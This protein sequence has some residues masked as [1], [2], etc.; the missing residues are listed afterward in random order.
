MTQEREGSTTTLTRHR[1][2]VTSSRTWTDVETITGVLDHLLRIH[3]A[4]LVV[5]DGACP[6]G[7]DEIAH[8]WCLAHGVPEERYPAD[9]GH[10]R[11]AGPLRNVKMVATRPDETLAFVRDN[12]RGATGCGELSER[13]QIPT[14]WWREEAQPANG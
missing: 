7:G 14:R 9:W 13:A 2:L 6:R 10:G 3:G 4:S 12:S 1:V 5:V 8:R 11:S